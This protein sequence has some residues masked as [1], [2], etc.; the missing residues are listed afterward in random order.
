SKK[1]WNWRKGKSVIHTGSFTQF[2]PQNNVY[3]YFRYNE[4]ETVMVIL[5]NARQE[6]TL[7]PKRF[8]ELIKNKN[9]GVEVMSGSK[10]DFD[11]E[12]KI[13]AKTAYILELE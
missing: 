5:N 10:I 7:D 13:S 9:Y 1:I 2:L 8:S 11:K 6:Q 3:V 4:S 12:I